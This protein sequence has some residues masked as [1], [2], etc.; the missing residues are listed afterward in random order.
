MTILRAAWLAPLIGA[1]LPTLAT[2]GDIC[3]VCAEPVATYRCSIEEG[4]KLSGV[5]GGERI[6]QYLCITELARIGGHGT[7]RVRA[8]QFTLCSGIAKTI[9][10]TGQAPTDAELAGAAKGQTAPDGSDAAQA[11]DKGPPQTLEELA[12]RTTESS[13]TQFKKAGE[14]VK[15]TARTAGQQI[16]KAGETV[17][18]AMKKTWG[19]VSSMFKEC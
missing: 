1:L 17:G 3:V 14:A 19:C 18:G 13:G 7:C 4:S 12:R 6:A 11:R 10:A 2:A 15:D 9:S 8:D 16:E 5:R